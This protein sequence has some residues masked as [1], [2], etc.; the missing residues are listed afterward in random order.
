MNEGCLHLFHSFKL[1]YFVITFNNKFNSN[2]FYYNYTS[3]CTVFLLQVT[4][5]RPFGLFRL[6]VTYDFWLL[7]VSWDLLYG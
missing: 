1:L 7:D 4:R 5:F 6:K 3:F 2:K